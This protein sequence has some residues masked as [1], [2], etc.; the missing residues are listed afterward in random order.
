MLALPALVRQ[1][2]RGDP[3]PQAGAQEVSPGRALRCP[4][5]RG[6]VVALHLPLPDP[7]GTRQRGCQE[8]V[9]LKAAPAP[10]PQRSGC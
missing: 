7:L 6:D 10:S 1:E 5:R 8:L 9:R 3:A 2:P 4:S